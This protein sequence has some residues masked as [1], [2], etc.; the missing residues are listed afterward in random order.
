[1]INVSRQTRRGVA[2]M[3]SASLVA[4]ACAP[5]AAAM[6]QAQLNDFGRRYAA[7]W[8][9]QNPDSLAAFYSEGG[10]LQVN[11]GAPAVGRA[12][13]RATAQG[14]MAAFPDMVVRLDFVTQTGT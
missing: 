6:N 13:V 2:L 8:S 11:A 1:M 5:R 3:L 14:F 7:A 10:S 9:S 12:A 4:V